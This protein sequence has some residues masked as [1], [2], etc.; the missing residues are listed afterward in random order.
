MLDVRCSTF[1]LLTVATMR[2]FIRASSLAAGV[3][4]NREKNY[5]FVVNR[6]VSYERHLWPRAS[7][8]IEKETN[9]SSFGGL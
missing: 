8:Q 7:S 4:S 9:E 5:I 6:V 1:N 2:S 3:Q